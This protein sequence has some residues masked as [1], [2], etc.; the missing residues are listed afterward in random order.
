MTG[1][2]CQKAKEDSCVTRLAVQQVRL[3]DNKFRIGQVFNDERIPIIKRYANHWATLES[4][5]RSA[6]SWRKDGYKHGYIRPPEKYAYNAA[7]SAKRDPA[8]PRGRWDSV[9]QSVKCK[10]KGKKRARARNDRTPSPTPSDR[11]NQN[12]VDINTMNARPLAP[13]LPVL[14]ESQ[15]SNPSQVDPLGRPHWLSLQPG[16]LAVPSGT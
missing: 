10:G 14:S 4:A 15:D 7:N 3:L 16:E 11:D 6:A 9:S 8:A 12:M 13:P 5:K 1:P 2:T